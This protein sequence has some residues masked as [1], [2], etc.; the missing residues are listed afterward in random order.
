MNPPPGR[1]VPPNAPV[2]P[3]LFFGRPIESGD[4]V[5]E[6]TRAQEQIAFISTT[7]PQDQV[8]LCRERMVECMTNII[9]EIKSRKG[10]KSEWVVAVSNNKIILPFIKELEGRPWGIIG[11]IIA[12]DTYKTCYAETALLP[13]VGGG[14]V[15]GLG[16]EN[17][18]T[19]KWL[20]FAD[21]VAEIDRLLELH[22]GMEQVI[23]T[24]ENRKKYAAE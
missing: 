2:L 9:T 24:E 16:Y 1:V 18:E 7:Q 10:T 15:N 11:I 8:R 3:A 23:W 5:A 17:E 4:S 13:V 14:F 21:L 20:V 6:N 19:K 12:P 22:A